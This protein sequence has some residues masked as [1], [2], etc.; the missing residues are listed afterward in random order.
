MTRERSDLD[1]GGVLGAWMNDAAPAS[2]PVIV[3]EEAFA[4]TMT[5][6]QV[7]GLSVAARR[8]GGPDRSGGLSRYCRSWQRRRSSS[9]VLGVRRV[10]GG[11]FGIGPGAQPDSVADARPATPPSPFPATPSPSPFPATPIAPTASV[12]V[13]RPQS[14]ATDGT[15]LWLLTETGSVARID[16]AT[17][18]VGA[19][20]QTGATDDLS[21]GIS[22][23]ANGVWVTEWN[24]ATLYRVDPTSLE[25]VATIPV[26][27]APKGVL[28]TDAAVWVADTHDGKVLRVD[29]A[30]NTVVAVD[31]GGADRQFRPELAGKRVR[32][33][34]GQRPER[35]SGR[36]D[37]P[38]HQR[39]PG[40]DQDPGRGDCM[41]R[42]RLH[43][44]GCLDRQAV[45]TGSPWHGSIPRRTWSPASPGRTGSRRSRP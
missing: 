41:W 43:G 29:P 22:V 5:A 18:T 42:L 37:R 24:T 30:T 36:P 25:V 23:G 9:A 19:G 14:L 38:D 20:V 16:P 28:A 3:L 26:G 45:A 15:V 13:V 32:Q 11:G 10:F 40:H 35:L 8:P 4:R 1:L 7:A 2:I 6:S 39:G 21:Q 17:N 12:A 27:K 31:H 34:L 44:D 33:H